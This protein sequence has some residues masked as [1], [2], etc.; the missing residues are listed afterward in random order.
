MAK[1]SK[2]MAALAIVDVNDL[3]FVA[4][5]SGKTMSE[6]EHEA[7]CIK[8][9]LA[10]PESAD[11]AYED[12]PKQICETWENEDGEVI[13][14]WHNL[15]G[16]ARHNVEDT[17]AILDLVADEGDEIFTAL[18]TSKKAYGLMDDEERL[19]IVFRPAPVDPEDPSK[20]NYAVS[21]LTNC[22]LNNMER[23]QATLNILGGIGCELGF[24]E[25]GESVTPAKYMKGIKDQEAKLTVESKGKRKNGKNQLRVTK[26]SAI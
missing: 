4:Q 2:L 14:V 7:T 1:K 3:E 6:G 15:T 23:T 18:G 17:K 20:G 26:Y 10:T 21:K 5:K 16:F 11:A 22:R 8:V 13:K 25:D 24:F 9:E 19:D 12:R